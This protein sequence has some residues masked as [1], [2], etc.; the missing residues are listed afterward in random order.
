MT[1][2]CVINAEIIIYDCLVCPLNKCTQRCPMELNMV[3]LASVVAHVTL[4][5]SSTPASHCQFWCCR[6]NVAS[7]AAAGVTSSV[8][9]P[10]ASH[11]HCR[12]RQHHI[13][14]VGAAGETLLVL[15]LPASRRQCCRRWRHIASVVAGLTLPVLSPSSRCQLKS[16]PTSH[17]QCRRRRHIASVV[18]A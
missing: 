13:A 15:L 3:P 12:R 7:V 11:C 5:V 2:I 4:P 16:S 8:L 9:S 14:S 1:W 10:L 6:Q 17:C 18:A